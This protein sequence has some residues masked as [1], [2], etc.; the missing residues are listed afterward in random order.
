MLKIKSKECW[1]TR[2]FFRYLLDI[3][4]VYPNTYNSNNQSKIEP[5]LL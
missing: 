5:A 1:S 3:N 4:V 2:G